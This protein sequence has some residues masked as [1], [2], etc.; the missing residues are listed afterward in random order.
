MLVSAFLIK[1]YGNETGGIDVREP[2]HTI[3]AKDRFALITVKG[4]NYVIDDVLMRGLEP[5]EL[6]AAQGFPCDYIINRDADGK[7]IPKYKQVARCGN[8]VCPALAEALVRAN[9]LTEEIR[10]VA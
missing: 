3:T 2:L 9:Y 4:V 7:T 6:F 1:Y 8:S 5:H 10:K